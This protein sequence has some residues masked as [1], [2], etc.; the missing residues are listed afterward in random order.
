MTDAIP[1]PLTVLLVEDD[2]GHAELIRACL[3]ES[4][5]LLTV[6]RLRDGQAAWDYLVGSNDQPGQLQ[7]GQRYLL[8]SDVRLPR[9]DGID[10]LR[11]V[12]ADNRL[13]LLPVFMLSTT[14]DERE[15]AACYQ[16]GAS[17]YFL[18]PVDFAAFADQMERL[19]WLFAGLRV[20]RF[21]GYDESA[22]APRF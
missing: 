20:A 11:R 3:Q 15:V 13:R 17:G 7:A 10:L 4:G 1:H 14:D 16:S 8:L 12:R 5:C 21:G 19:A 22:T 9:L 18:K 2:D 6:S